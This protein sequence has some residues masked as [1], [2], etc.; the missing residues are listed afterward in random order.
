M[1]E[2][3]NTQVEGEGRLHTML[4][5]PEELPAGHAPMPAIPRPPPG[6]G[7]RSKKGAPVALVVVAILAL[8]VVAAFGTVLALGYT[9]EVGDY[10]IGLG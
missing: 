8:V 2:V 4:A 10:E 1:R 3:G 9:I 6:Q 7:A 5:D